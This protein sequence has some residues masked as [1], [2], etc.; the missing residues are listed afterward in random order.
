MRQA[1]SRFWE[2]AA[3]LRHGRGHFQRHSLGLVKW[4][5]WRFAGR[6]QQVHHLLG[7]LGP[8]LGPMSTATSASALPAGCAGLPPQRSFRLVAIGRRLRFRSV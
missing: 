2:V 5:R 4:H 1:I 7:S 6:I 3:T 8:K